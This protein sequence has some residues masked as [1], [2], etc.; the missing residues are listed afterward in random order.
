[1]GLGDPEAF[2][3]DALVDEIE[4]EEEDRPASVAA[5]RWGVWPAPLGAGRIGVAD[6]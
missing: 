2:A 6:S 1:M 4:F 5:A 3:D